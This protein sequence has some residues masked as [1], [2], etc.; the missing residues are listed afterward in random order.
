ML[1]YQQ[2]IKELWLHQKLLCV[3]V[4]IPTALATFYY[5][6]I[7][8]DLY[9]SESQFV[10]RGPQK[11]SLSALGVLFGSGFSASNS[12]SQSLNAFLKSR[13]TLKTLKEKIPYQEMFQDRGAD[14]LSRF[15]QPVLWDDSFEA[16][17]GYYLKHITLFTDPISSITHFKVKAFRAEEAALINET[18]LQIGEAF[19]NKLNDRAQKDM[20]RFAREELKIAEQSAREASLAFSSYRTRAQKFDPTEHEQLLVNK[21][22]TLKQLEM[23]HAALTAAEDEARKQ[24][25]Y[26]ARI[27]Q[28]HLPDVASE[29]RRLYTIF[30][31]LLVSSLLFGV[32]KMILAG[33]REHHD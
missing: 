32:L 1:E 2:K 23:R 25:L 18:L 7:A 8:S 4:L 30:T 28:P 12:D 13:D 9:V 22:L 15:P 29:P 14:L 21:E 5:G 10:V 11:Q 6:I 31:V 3:V 20:I 24:A 27:E 19:I 16:L 33:V 26:L 17:H